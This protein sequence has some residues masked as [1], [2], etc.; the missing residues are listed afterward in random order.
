M[1][2]C[3]QSRC[4]PTHDDRS[5]ELPERSLDNDRDHVHNG[6]GDILRGHRAGKI[7]R[8]PIR[9]NGMQLGP[10]N[11]QDV[12]RS[13]HQQNIHGRQSA[14]TDRVL[15]DFH[16]GH[17]ERVPGEYR[18]ISSTDDYFPTNNR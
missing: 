17:P 5:D 1:L 14:N 7:P 13:A 3:A 11:L 16:A 10:G 8:H 2:A 15:F 9:S 18:F 4:H 12:H 6:H